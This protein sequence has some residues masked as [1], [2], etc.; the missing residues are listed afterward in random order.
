MI[1]ISIGDYH[2]QFNAMDELISFLETAGLLKYH[3]DA[4]KEKLSKEYEKEIYALKEELGTLEF[5]ING[6]R[7]E[8]RSCKKD[9]EYRSSSKEAVKKSD[10]LMYFENIRLELN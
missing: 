6:A 9:L 2:V 3:D 7:E 4:L 1:G 10:V 5:T 8:I